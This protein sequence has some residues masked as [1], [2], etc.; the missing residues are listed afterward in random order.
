MYL[1]RDTN[2]YPSKEVRAS[3]LRIY[4]VYWRKAIYITSWTGIS[5]PMFIRNLSSY[6]YGMI[7][8]ILKS[9]LISNV[10][11]KRRMDSNIL[12]LINNNSYWGTRHKFCLPVHGQR[13]RT[14]ASTQKAKK[15]RR[16]FN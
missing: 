2:L 8:T 5:Y 13:T 12:H 3:L 16:V 10:R 11:I 1:F 7:Y 6:R 4:G 14:N 15:F 9:Y